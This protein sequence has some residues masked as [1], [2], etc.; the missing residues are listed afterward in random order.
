MTKEKEK[1]KCF[2][3]QAQIRGHTFR[4]DPGE[5]LL[6]R[7]QWPTGRIEFHKRTRHHYPHIEIPGMPCYYL[8]MWR[9]QATVQP[10]PRNSLPRGEGRYF[11]SAVTPHL[12]RWE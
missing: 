9:E 12:Q 8:H 3:P 2:S 5:S 6:F 10:P 1:V 4:A 11:N 7:I